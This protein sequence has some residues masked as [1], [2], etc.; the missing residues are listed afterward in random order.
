MCLSVS[1]NEPGIKSETS[2]IMWHVAPESKIQLINCELSPKFLL[3]NSS[4]PD[5]RAIDAYIFWS[6]LFL[7]LS[8]AQLPFSLKRTCF[9]RF[10]LSFGGF[11][12]FSIR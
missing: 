3:G 8:R 10:S 2:G 11:G 4:L 1:S 7:L 5:I 6:S 9:R 12:H